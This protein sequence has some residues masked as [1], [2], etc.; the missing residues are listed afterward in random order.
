MQ[1]YGFSLTH[2][3]PYK[4]STYDSA[5]IPENTGQWK[6]VV[7]HILCSEKEKKTK[8]NKLKVYKI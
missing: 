6:R 4:K 3:L 8:C 2:I 7:S 5:L 1:E